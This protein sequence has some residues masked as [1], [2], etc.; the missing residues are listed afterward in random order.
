M[1]CVTRDGLNDREGEGEGDGDGDPWS[2]GT[3]DCA[4]CGC[5]SFACDGDEEK[6]DDFCTYMFC[7]SCAVCQARGRGGFRVM[8]CPFTFHTHV[9]AYNARLFLSYH[10]ISHHHAA[11]YKSPTAS[12]VLFRATSTYSNEASFTS[13]V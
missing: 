13:N 11:L 10:C 3:T 6:I 12:H 2:A 9:H 5:L 8:R 4:C 1:T 7:F